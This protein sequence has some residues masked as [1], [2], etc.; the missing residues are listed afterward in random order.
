[1]GCLLRLWNSAVG[2]QPNFKQTF[3]G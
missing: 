2:S 1:L 3:K